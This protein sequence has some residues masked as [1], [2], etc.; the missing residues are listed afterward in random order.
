[1]KAVVY[2]GPKTVSVKEVPDARLERP[3]DALVRITT[4]DTCGSDLHRYDGRTDMQPGR[5]LGHENLG[6]VIEVGD[7][8]ELVN[9]ALGIE[10]ETPDR[11]SQ[12]T[13]RMLGWFSLGLGA[14][15]FAATSRLSRLCGV[16]DS[17]TARTVL[18][19]AGVREL[20]HAAALL[21]PR[22]AGGGRGRGS[23]GTSWTWLPAVGP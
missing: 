5:V 21:V 3:A 20:G 6:E 8:V 19:A 1:M 17:R 4:T 14:A 13:A 18:R 11:R 12:G 2:Y 15:A 22:R 7:T 9:D 23:P 10:R 16:D